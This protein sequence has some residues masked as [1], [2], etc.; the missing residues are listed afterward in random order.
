MLLS[1]WC[2]QIN[3]YKWAI[4]PRGKTITSLLDYEPPREA[5]RWCEWWMESL[6]RSSSAK[7][8]LCTCDALPTD[9][10]INNQQ[11][12]RCPA[13]EMDNVLFPSANLMAEN[14]FIEYDFDGTYLCLI[15][16]SWL[17]HDN[18]YQL[19]LLHFFLHISPYKPSQACC[20]DAA[21]RSAWVVTS[22]VWGNTD[23]SDL[24][25]C[26]LAAGIVH[27]VLQ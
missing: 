26:H 7:D 6:V 5:V 22:F 23:S 21:V 12:V 20:C 9:A 8:W 25:S 4:V 2:C 24:W 13:L 11:T 18:Y 1:N 17:S 10:W 15:W 14:G 19:L 3:Q 16:P 27:A